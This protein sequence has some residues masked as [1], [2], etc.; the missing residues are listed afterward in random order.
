MARKNSPHDT[1]SVEQCLAE[2]P[3]ASYEAEQ[4]VVGCVLLRGDVMDELAHLLRPG[5]FFDESLGTI[6]GS[7][8]RM[9]DQR[10]RIDTATI[11]T[12]LKRD[13]SLDKVGGAAA[14]VRIAQSV[15]SFHHASYYATQIRKETLLRDL[16]GVATD[17]LR[18]CTS[19]QYEPEECF[20]RHDTRVAKVQDREAGQQAKDSAT[21]CHEF[22]TAL[23]AKLAGTSEECVATGFTRLDQMLGGGLRNGH[24]VIV[25]ARPGGGKSAFAM[26]VAQHVACDERKPVLMFSME[27]S[28]A[29]LGER[30]LSSLSGVNAYRMRDG[31]ITTAERERIVE[32]SSRVHGAPLWVDDSSSTSLRKISAMARTMKRKH[33]LA[34]IIVDYLQLMDPGQSDSREVREQQVA[35]LSRGLKNLATDLKVPVMCL[36]QLNRQAEQDGR[37]GSHRPRLS[38]LRESGAI[39]QDANVVLFTHREELFRPEDPELRGKAELIIAKQRSGDLG[40]VPVLFDKGTTTFRNIEAE[41]CAAFD[42][43]NQS[44]GFE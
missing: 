17:T 27:M 36:A 42:D 14:L 2:S 5:D 34:L 7:L 3:P 20:Q 25:A 23:E 31:T 16:M 18:D 41:R 37:G 24:L 8:L 43:F 9:H 44:S 35:R 11:L 10:E 21:I 28:S 15:P 4:A 29:E 6:W 22:F 12:R 26:N 13:G 40:S 33:G 38:H 32:A 19:G 39:E 1:R 30:M